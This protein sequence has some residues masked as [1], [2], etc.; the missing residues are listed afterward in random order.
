MH[1]VCLFQTVCISV[2]AGAEW[3]YGVSVEYENIHADAYV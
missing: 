2:K 3:V 1:V